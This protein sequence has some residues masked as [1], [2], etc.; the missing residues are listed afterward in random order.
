MSLGVRC[1][2]VQK[3]PGGYE[4]HRV[5]DRGCFAVVYEG[6]GPGGDPVAVKVLDSN[7]PQADPRFRR[8]IAVTKEL[9]ESPHVVRYHG[10]GE[11][12]AGSPYLAM[13]L[14]DGFT[15]ERMIRG[16]RCLAEQ[17]ACDLMVQVCDALG[18]LHKLGVTHGDIKPANIMLVRGDLTVKLIDFG[19]VRDAQGLLRLFEKEGMM[20]SHEFFDDLDS[21]MLMGT[22]DYIA[23]EQI[24]DARLTEGAAAATDTPAD[25]FGLGAIFYQLLT[26][27]RPWPFEPTATGP[28]E[29]RRQ[30]RD[31]L[32][33][34][35]AVDSVD[36]DRPES[37]N[38]VLWT[39]IA[40]SLQLDPKLR[41]G[42]ARVLAED[43]RRYLKQGAGVPT[44][45]DMSET[46]PGAYLADLI[47]D[48]K[49]E[50]V[51]LF[52]I[53]DVRGHA[54]EAEPEVEAAEPRGG[55]TTTPEAGHRDETSNE[56]AEEPLLTSLL[57]IAAAVA[58]FFLL[59]AF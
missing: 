3:L 49:L 44:N 33:S 6:R 55:P 21:G 35:L 32:E 48:V 13:E 53:A 15:L 27:E 34:R 52:G 29:Y 50:P 42:D 40:K 23:P 37:V 47:D 25:V 20:L 30:V 26:G 18:R 24:A 57:L 31:Y 10:H 8:E 54:Q 58:V 17:A 28:D 9:P 2:K 43:I 46:M 51:E 4:L 5:L 45:L 38:P 1:D 22:P 36:L 39:I 19:L 56:T 41:Q 11:T 59:S 16:G 12:E 7:H 14:I